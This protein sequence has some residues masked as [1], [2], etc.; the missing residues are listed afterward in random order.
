MT[1]GHWVCGE[2]WTEGLSSYVTSVE[3]L[4][5]T[6]FDKCNLVV[7]PSVF[8]RFLPPDLMEKYDS[9]TSKKFIEC[10]PRMKACPRPGCAAV[11]FAAF[12]PSDTYTDVACSCDSKWC[13][14]CSAEDHRPAK[15]AQVKRGG[16]GH[17]TRT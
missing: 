7:P 15:C 1:C 9:W 12:P 11:A 14:N 17:A 4:R 5:T 10:S 16:Q 13:F 3:S 2:C 6:C 8:A